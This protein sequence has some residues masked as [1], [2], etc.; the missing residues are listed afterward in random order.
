MKTHIASAFDKNFLVRGLATYRSIYQHTPDAHFWVL[1][2]DNETKP[3][4]EKMN[5]KNVSCITLEE[6]NNKELLETRSKRNNTEFAMTSKSCFLSY[7]INTNKVKINELLILTD[8]DMIFYPSVREFIEKEKIDTKNCI[9]LTPHKFSKE[10]EK[11]IPEVGYYNG[12]FITFRI[13]E[14]SKICIDTWAK[15][16]INWCYLWHDYVNNWHTDQM[17]I[18]EWKTKYKGV[19]DLPDKGVNAGN[20]NIKRFQVTKSKSGNFFVDGDP[21]VCY[22]FHGLK[23]YL[24]KNGIIKPYPICI[25]NKMIYKE[26]I[27]DLQKAL[28]DVLLIDPNW[29]YG[30]ASYPGIL[31]IIKQSVWKNF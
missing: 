29:K 10:K 15:Q 23:M 16:C 24:T 5:L 7:L 26:Y 2:L 8:V 1:C 28:E 12:G 11:M 18:D 20:W 17:Y 21:L 27:K 13:N 31:R 14:T 6:M 22:H 30:F 3:M 9:F 25:Y 19:M 4:M